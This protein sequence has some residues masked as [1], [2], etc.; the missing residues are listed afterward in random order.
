MQTSRPSKT[1]FGQLL[2]NLR[3]FALQPCL[4]SC[5]DFC[6]PKDHAARRWV[7]TA[8]ER[9]EAAELCKKVVGHF[10]EWS[11][12]DGVK[13]LQKWI[14]CEITELLDGPVAD[15]LRRVS[16]G[17][18]A[19]FAGTVLER[20][21]MVWQG[22]CATVK[23]CTTWI[24]VA[25]DKCARTSN[26][27]SDMPRLP[28]ELF[29]C[30][31]QLSGNYGH[32][33]TGPCIT[34]MNR[35]RRSKTADDLAAVAKVVDMLLCASLRGSLPFAP[36][37][38]FSGVHQAQLSLRRG[39]PYYDHFHVPV[40]AAAE[41]YYAGVAVEYEGF[42]VPEQLKI[43]KD[44][45]T[46]ESLVTAHRTHRATQGAILS[47]AKAA[48]LVGPGGSI[49]LKILA[50]WPAMLEATRESGGSSSSASFPR[51]SPPPEDARRGGGAGAASST[52]SRHLASVRLIYDLYAALQDQDWLRQLSGHTSSR[53]NP[54]SY[55]AYLERVGTAIVEE[56]H[57][58][59]NRAADKRRAALATGKRVSSRS[60][61]SDPSFVDAI[62]SLLEWS[63]HTIKAALRGNRWFY[64]A[65]DIAFKSIL[66]RSR[67]LPESQESGTGGHADVLA[68]YF[69]RLLRRN[70]DIDDEQLRHRLEPLLRIFQ[71]LERDL[72]LRHYR[73]RLRDR[74]VSRKSNLDQEKYILTAFTMKV[75]RGAMHS[76]TSMVA[77][78]SEIPGRNR[79]YQAALAEDRRAGANDLPPWPF[80][81]AVYTTALWPKFYQLSVRPPAAAVRCMSHFERYYKLK[82]AGRSLRWQ[83]SQGT[84]SVSAQVGSTVRRLEVATVQLFA[85]LA[86]ED[87]DSWEQE[88]LASSLEMD[89]EV[90]KRVM[91]PLWM[92]QKVKNANI[93]KRS[94]T[95]FTFNGDVAM[96]ATR[97]IQYHAPVYPSENVWKAVVVDR[98]NH[99]DALLVRVMKSRKELGHQELV[100]EV[101]SAADSLGGFRPNNRDVSSA[102]GRRPPTQSATDTNTNTCQHRQIKLRIEDL[103]ER[104]YISRLPSGQYRYLA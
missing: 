85:L 54:S 56:R 43:V 84:A 75:G 89:L 13:V 104:E 100:H 80:V 40:V 33:V 37:S 9:V 59:L 70:Q 38:A 19:E 81:A 14:V 52:T 44:L 4:L 94:G 55:C 36:F 47:A 69:D 22:F 46:Q 82:A 27:R 58:R 21:A 34:V 5:F 74:L 60:S 67:E 29:G 68:H 97:R 76:M 78:T 23:A 61:A 3:R 92:R 49:A 28:A 2:A 77:D 63:L 102:V 42:P 95:S 41:E 50:A 32:L 79:E 31:S 98:K 7:P 18:D 11:G 12:D 93:I 57:A 51:G 66:A 48:L 71:F 17:G 39:M 72:F 99:I 45:L 62:S 8:S 25:V 20:L 10:V 101:I 90:L 103:I 65:H 30:F 16:H 35:C 6:L 91:H 24:L 88:D 87:R 15:D 83:Y 26:V 96:C 1:G 53:V 73:E 64:Q 86:F